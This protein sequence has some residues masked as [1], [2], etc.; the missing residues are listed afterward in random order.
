M[1][2]AFDCRGVR[3]PLVGDGGKLEPMLNMLVSQGKT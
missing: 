2:L 1:V 3:L